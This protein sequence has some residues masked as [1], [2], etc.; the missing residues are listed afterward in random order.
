MR[1]APSPN[2]ATAS[3]GER[4]M[5]IELNTLEATDL[6]TAL[7][8]ASKVTDL[9]AELASA[10]L[11]LEHSN[12]SC[13]DA[14]KRNDR[15]EQETYA[16]R[17]NN[18]EVQREISSIRREIALMIA[19]S[20]PFFRENGFS[21]MF[22]LF[23]AGQK[24]PCIK[25]LRLLMNLDLKSAKDIV[26]G[27]FADGTRPELFALNTVFKGIVGGLGIDTMR[28]ELCKVLKTDL[29]VDDLNRVLHGEFHDGADIK[30]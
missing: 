11:D 17:Q 30:F 29:S 28:E 3:I 5:K 16:L 26:E 27:L 2:G 20:K 6:F 23:R 14:W 7:A 10:R 21:R 22:G 15:L 4:N 1:N 18:E 13:R 8:Q 19:Q 9:E 12:E 24:I 25:E